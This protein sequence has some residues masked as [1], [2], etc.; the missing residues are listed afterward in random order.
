MAFS[1][2]VTEK[3]IEYLKVAPS[4]LSVNLAIEIYRDLRSY[5]K[6]YTEEK[7]LAD[8]NGAINKIAMASIEIDAKDGVEGQTS[9]SDNGTS[10]SYGNTP[11]PKAYATVIPFAKVV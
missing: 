7:I 10:R 4:T 1:D 5:P 8:M 6:S 11:T 3:A 9:H 2:D